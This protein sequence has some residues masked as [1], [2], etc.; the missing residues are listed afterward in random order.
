MYNVLMLIKVLIKE[1]ILN[2]TPMCKSVLSVSNRTQNIRIQTRTHF[3]SNAFV[4]KR[5]Q[6]QQ[7]ETF[8]FNKV[9]EGECLLWVHSICNVSRSTLTRSHSSQA[10]AISLERSVPIASVFHVV[11]VLLRR[12]WYVTAP[13]DTPVVF[14]VLLS[15]PFRVKSVWILASRTLT[16]NSKKFDNYRQMHQNRSNKPTFVYYSWKYKCLN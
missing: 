8:L 5:S 2:F 9:T 11:F 16:Q 3:W 7:R 15:R 10:H 13:M 14:S 12:S 4:K 6:S 1:N